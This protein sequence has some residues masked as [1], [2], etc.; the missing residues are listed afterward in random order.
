MSWRKN[1]IP[2]NQ[3]HINK[4]SSALLK[5]YTSKYYPHLHY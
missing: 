4:V 3:K 2:Q 5:S 1:A